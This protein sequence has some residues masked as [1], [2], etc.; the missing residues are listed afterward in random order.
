MYNGIFDQS[1]LSGTIWI[2]MEHF[3]WASTPS[4]KYGNIHKKHSNVVYHD[5]SHVA[6]IDDLDL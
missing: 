1:I 4:W 5:I 3:A 2:I 6:R